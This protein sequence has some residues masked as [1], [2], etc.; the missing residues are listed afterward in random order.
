MQF[1]DIEQLT[2]SSLLNL[3][4]HMHSNFAE[5]ALMKKYLKCRHTM[6]HLT[7]LMLATTQSAG[8]D[9]CASRSSVAAMSGKTINE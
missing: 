7:S 3:R 5:T 4:I 2:G 9:P 1:T 8:D 6:Q